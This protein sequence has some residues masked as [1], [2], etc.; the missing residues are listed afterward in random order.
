MKTALRL[1]AI[2]VGAALTLSACAQTSSMDSMPS[3]NLAMGPSLNA[4]IVD[5][6][7][8]EVVVP[9]GHLNDPF[10]TFYET[11]TSNNGSTWT[12]STPKGSS[13][14]GGIVIASPAHGASAIRSFDN[15]H[16]SALTPLSMG[17]QVMSGG[18]IIPAIA[19]SPS[20]LSVQGGRSYWVTKQGSVEMSWSPSATPI[21][22][23]TATSLNHS[24]GG[25]ACG[26]ATI[27]SV[28]MNASGELAVGVRC[29]HGGTSAVLTR[30]TTAS[31]WKVAELPSMAADATMRL[32]ATATGFIALVRTGGAAP[33]L[34]AVAIHG[35][36][37]TL[38]PSVGLMYG[39]L[40]ASV[41]DGHGG[42]DALI[43]TSKGCSVVDLAP[44]Q[45]VTSI[46][47]GLPTNAQS[48]ARTSLHGTDVLDVVEVSGGKASFAVLGTK[49]M[50]RSIQSIKVAI[51]YGSSA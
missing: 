36:D 35:N 50:W 40:R 41:P 27:N 49:G 37:A 47:A 33:S 43:A 16:V 48:I 24:P 15:S 11:F 22:L 10:N 13:T 23:A 44:G 25:T 1:A 3:M 34:R 51:P 42:Y 4:G 39:L 2:G 9:M 20:A 21:T 46:G 30:A 45:S 19:Q 28:A 14:N 38:S 18:E 6:S 26:V 8:S 7:T 5:G 12:L 32:D 31:S 29:S 17:T